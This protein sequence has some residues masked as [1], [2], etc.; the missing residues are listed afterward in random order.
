LPAATVIEIYAFTAI[1]RSPPLPNPP[2]LATVVA[3]SSSIH[4]RHEL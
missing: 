3:D 2:M 1:Y 4:N